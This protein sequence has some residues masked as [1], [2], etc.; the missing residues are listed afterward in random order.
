M[1]VGPGDMYNPTIKIDPDDEGLPRDWGTNI[2]YVPWFITVFAILVLSTVAV[3]IFVARL[4]HKAISK[5]SI[6]VLV[7]GEALVFWIFMD[8]LYPLAALESIRYI[9]G[10]SG[11]L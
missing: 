6:F 3:A 5:C 8:S 1:A 11:L 7:L 9:F 10:W 2:P 4:R